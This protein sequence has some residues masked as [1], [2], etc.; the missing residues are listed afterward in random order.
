[1]FKG[2]KSALRRYI[3]TNY[4]MPQKAINEG[5]E[6]HLVIELSLDEKGNVTGKKVIKGNH[7]EL[8]D[9]AYRII[10]LMPAW[11]P[12]TSGGNP[13]ATAVKLKIKLPL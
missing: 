11:L 5:W 4:T 12:A 7:Q 6:D 9:E 3:K 13:I 8:I 10:D 2:G 1:M